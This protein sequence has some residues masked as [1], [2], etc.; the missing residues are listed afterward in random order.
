MFMETIMKIFVLITSLFLIITAVADLHVG[1]GYYQLLRWLT[2]ICS[3]LCA[4]NF[5]DKST[6]FFVLFCIIAVLFNPIAP[7]YLD[8]DIWKTIDLITGVVFTVPILTN[9]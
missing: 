9:K 4:L 1:Y 3:I 2:T 7:I 8:K 6:T 5:K